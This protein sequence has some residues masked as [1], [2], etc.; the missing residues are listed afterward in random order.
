MP[1]RACRFDSGSR[2]HSHG[3]HFQGR[4]QGGWKNC[5]GPFGR[6]QGRPKGESRRLESMFANSGEITAPWGV[7]RLPFSRLPSAS[8]TPTFNHL[9]IRRMML[10]SVTRCC[11]VSRT[12]LS[13]DQSGV[14]LRSVCLSSASMPGSPGID[15]HEDVH[16]ALSGCSSDVLH[17]RPSSDRPCPALKMLLICDTTAAA[18]PPLDDAQGW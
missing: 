1:A 11:I 2:Y 16:A 13:K 10:R 8:T 17:S 5:R 14:S 4:C 15:Q 6:T 18:P 7:P 12:L 3:R 9:P